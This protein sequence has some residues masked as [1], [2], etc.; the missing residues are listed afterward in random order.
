MR[1]SEAGEGGPQRSKR[2]RRPLPN[3]TNLATGVED[4]VRGGVSVADA[5]RSLDLAPTTYYRW[6]SQARLGFE[7][8]SGVDEEEMRQVVLAAAKAAF[9]EHGFNISLAAIAES[10]GVA[11]QTIYN[12]YDGKKALFLDVL[13]I[14][15]AGLRVLDHDPDGSEPLADGLRLFGKCY[16]EMAVDDDA[17]KANRLTISQYR[18]DPEVSRMIFEL[19]QRSSLFGLTTRVSAYLRKKQAQGAVGPGETNLIADAFQSAVMGTARLR[20]LSGVDQSAAQLEAHLNCTVE[21]FV[22]ALATDSGR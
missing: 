10:A 20:G 9:M 3:R 4:L 17:L 19:A 21:L 15:Y 22:R 16:M 11:R 5:C 6:R 1:I 12:L 18:K 14:I 13:Q 7:I 2:G 8:D